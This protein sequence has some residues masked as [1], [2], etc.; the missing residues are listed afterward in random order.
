[1]STEAQL[2]VERC[3]EAGRSLNCLVCNVGDGRPATSDATDPQE[4][5]RVLNMNLLSAVVV[6]H[7]AL[8]YLIEARG[9]VILI[10]SIAGVRTLG[11]PVAY[12]AAKAALNS[13]CSAWSRKWAQYGVRVNAVA[14]GD[15]LFPGS[16]WDLKSTADPESVKHHMT[17]DI[18]LARFG[19]PEEIAA[20]CFFLASLEARYI[21]GQVIAVD[22][23]QVA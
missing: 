6:L 4:W 14:P 19:R 2:V 5:Q 21:T 9:S 13:A 10:S 16:T 11:A 12:E 22:G 17:K 3:V 7:H 1:M 23:G 8:P 18:P 15:I 20:T